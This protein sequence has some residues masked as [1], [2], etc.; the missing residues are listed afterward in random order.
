MDQGFRDAKVNLQNNGYIVKA[1]YHQPSG[2]QLSTIEANQS[3]LVTKIRHHVEHANGF[4]KQIWKIFGLT[5]ESLSIPH[6]MEDFKIGAALYNRFYVDYQEN[7]TE[8]LDL[9]SRMLARVQLQNH[10][11]EVVRSKNFTAPLKKKPSIFKDDGFFN[12]PRS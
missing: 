5:W 1:P 11:S 7:A 8:S 12:I 9:A 2:V 4:M 10:L 3:R 6:L